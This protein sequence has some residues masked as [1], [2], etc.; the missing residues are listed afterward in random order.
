MLKEGRETE[1]GCGSAKDLTWDALDV[2][3][4]LDGKEPSA[5]EAWS[6]EGA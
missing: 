6:Q 5:H 1:G 4:W 2:W 3:I